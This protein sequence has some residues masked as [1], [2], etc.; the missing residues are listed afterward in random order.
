MKKD[1]CCIPTRES[2][3]DR[4]FHNLQDGH[5]DVS[6][7]FPKDGILYIAVDYGYKG[8]GAVFAF[9]EDGI[10]KILDEYASTNETTQNFLDAVFILTSILLTEFILGG[11][12]LVAAP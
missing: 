11:Q 3:G 2:T 9:E 5:T 1:F 6:I 4:V 8:N 10:L 7:E 12:S